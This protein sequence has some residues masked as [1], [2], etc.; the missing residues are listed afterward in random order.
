MLN[1]L[2]TNPREKNT[3]ETK[4]GFCDTLRTNGVIKAKKV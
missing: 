1:S 2:K 3:M 4:L